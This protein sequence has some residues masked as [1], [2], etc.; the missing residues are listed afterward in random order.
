MKILTELSR[1][2]ADLRLEIGDE[3]GRI[4]STLVSIWD[5]VR[6]G[7]EPK[8]QDGEKEGSNTGEQHFLKE[9]DF[10]LKVVKESLGR[11]TGVVVDAVPPRFRASFIHFK[12]ANWGIEHV[13]L[14]GFF[15]T[16]VP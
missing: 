1:E 6:E 16:H 3:R 5:W 15:F 4:H 11:R 14:S 7:E 13:R 10:L 8:G 12:A 9:L 2:A